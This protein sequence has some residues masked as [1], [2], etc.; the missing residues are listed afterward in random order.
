[1]SVW[2]AWAGCRCPESTGE[3][4]PAYIPGNQGVYTPYTDQVPRYGL[5]Y[6]V[7]RRNTGLQGSPAAD[8]GVGTSEFS[9]RTA[10]RSPDDAG[11]EMAQA[12]DRG[13]FLSLFSSPR[14]MALGGIWGDPRIPEPFCWDEPKNPGRAASLLIKILRPACSGQLQNSKLPLGPGLEGGAVVVEGGAA[15]GVRLG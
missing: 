6:V 1:M 12:K 8:G 2:T 15:K 9:P 13:F 11:R 7:P 14:P 4:E 5:R 3:R 10:G